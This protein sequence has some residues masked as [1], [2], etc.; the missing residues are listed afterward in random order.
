[1]ASQRMN[2]YFIIQHF[3]NQS[4]LLVDPPRPITFPFISKLLRFTNTL[5]MSF[6]DIFKKLTD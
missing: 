4:M 1:M 2:N 5:K 6:L 3:V